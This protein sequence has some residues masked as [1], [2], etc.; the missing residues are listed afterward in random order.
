MPIDLSLLRAPR[1]NRADAARNYDALLEA[2]REVFT[3]YG[4]DAPL[5]EVARR[6]GVGIATLYRNFPTRDSLLE[7]VYLT[8]VEAVCRMANGLQGEDPWVGITSWLSRFVDYVATKRAVAVGFDRDAPVYKAC[9]EALNEAGGPLLAR[10]QSA[11]VMRSDVNIDD[12]M[13]Y[14][15]AYTTVNFASAEQR[16]KMLQIA[17]D[18]L[19]PRTP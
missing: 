6:V 14:A 15:M 8:E 17:F 18:G 16:D 9:V 2:A 12:V 3:E 11:G 7:N 13:R 19:R 1:P 4:A 10:A 5:D